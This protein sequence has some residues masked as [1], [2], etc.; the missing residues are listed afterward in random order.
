M[1]NKKS[2]R[3]FL[4]VIIGCLCMVTCAGFVSAAGAA[5]TGFL[6]DQAGV[7]DDRQKKDTEKLLKRFLE[8]TGGWFFVLTTADMG[9]LEPADY[10]DI[11]LGLNGQLSEPEGGLALMYCTTTGDVI[12]YV[13]G[14][15]QN[16]VDQEIQE[17]VMDDVLK[18]GD[19]G[20]NLLEAVENLMDNLS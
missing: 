16:R 2:A 7:L 19:F 15:F 10:F 13:Y 3:I 14:R 11:V 4:A 12:S 6:F 20:D 18:A 1:S 17:E 8:E 9:D 5:R